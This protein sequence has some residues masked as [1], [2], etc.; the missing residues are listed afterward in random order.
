MLYLVTD[1]HRS[2]FLSACRHR[3]PPARR[4][5][6]L[7]PRDNLLKVDAMAA[8][9]D[10]ARIWQVRLAL[11]AS[12]K[13]WLTAWGKAKETQRQ[14]RCWLKPLFGMNSN[15]TKSILINQLTIEVVSLKRTG[16]VI[17]FVIWW[18]RIYFMCGISRWGIRG[19]WVPW[20]W[21]DDYIQSVERWAGT[22]TARILVVMPQTV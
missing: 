11:I 7:R 21:T 19:R 20:T 10:C 22:T 15:R 17:E 16:L 13:A 1:T 2:F 9:G 4:N 12:A 14:I 6:A 3:S 5:H 18:C 8:V